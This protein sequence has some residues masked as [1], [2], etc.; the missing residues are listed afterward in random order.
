M[1]QLVRHR[2]AG[3]LP[4]MLGVA[5]VA[6]AFAPS[7][8]S[9]APLDTVT[10]TGGGPAAPGFVGP[11]SD[12]SISAQSGTSGQN[13]SGTVSFTIGPFALS[14]PVTCLSVTGPDQGAGSAGSPT[15]AVLNF[16]EST[17]PFAG[18]NTVELVDNG[19]NGADAIIATPDFRSPT[20]CSLPVPG[21]AGTLTDGRAVVYDAPLADPTSTDVTCSPGTFAPGDGAVC[22]AT[23]TD[24]ASAGQSTPTGIVTF[25]G[26]GTG[27]FVGSPCMLSGSGA[28]AS[29]AV[30]LSSFPLG[31]QTITASYGGDA[32]HATSMGSTTITVA[33]PASTAGCLA[34]GHGRITAAD[35]DRASFR[36]LALG[37]PTV[38]AEFYRD[39]GPA[40]PFRLVSS[41]VDAVTCSPD[42]TLASVFGTATVNGADSVQYRIDIQ[43]TGWERGKDTYRVRLSNGYDSGAQ[44]IRHGD[45]EIRIG[46]F[47]HDHEDANANHYKSGV[48]LDGG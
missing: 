26:S 6:L 39:N 12:I 29:C 35:G 9:A 4:A 44:L 34:F 25:T 17:G 5:F 11:F 14:G 10:A 22:R 43:L 30:S 40:N 42:A 38:G 1:S 41:S 13:P 45:V 3:W 19:G 47:R 48:E 24:T 15:T 32:A 46:D 8:A 28:S 7:A 2:W 20:D 27:T 18:I 37:S 36:G 23:V 31:G 33:V 16:L 21:T